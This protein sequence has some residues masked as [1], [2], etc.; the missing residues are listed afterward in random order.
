MAPRDKLTEPVG[1]VPLLRDRA[2]M[3]LAAGVP[4]IVALAPGRPDRVA[5]LDGLEVERLVVRDAADGMGASIAAGARA[6]PDG[7]RLMILPA[8]V[9]DVTTADL[10]G[11]LESD[12][13]GILQGASA[14]RFG[15][16]VVFPPD[17]LPALRALGGDRGA[18][19]V[20]LA[21][22]D[23]LRLHELPGEAAITDLDTP[24]AWAAWRALRAAERPA[25]G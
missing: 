18:R 11:M 7:T 20:I 1:G 19:S 10:R 6:A 23:R 9:P 4:V 21:N 3:A 17:L 24:E 14:G 8:D 15:H 25:G 12:W 16:P 22:E 2:L 13:S 5:A